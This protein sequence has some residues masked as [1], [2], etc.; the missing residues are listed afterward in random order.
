MVHVGPASPSRLTRSFR[1]ALGACSPARGIKLLDLGA[2]PIESRRPT[3]M[4]F[5]IALPVEGTRPRNRSKLGPPR[6]DALRSRRALPRAWALLIALLGCTPFE[7]AT[8]PQNDAGPGHA[9]PHR[10]MGEPRTTRRKVRQM[11]VPRRRPPDVQTP[12]CNRSPT[13]SNVR[14]SSAAPGDELATPDTTKPDAGDRQPGLEGH[15]RASTRNSQLLAS[16]RQGRVLATTAHD[17]QLQGRDFV[18]T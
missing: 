12:A 1:Q 3:R 14:A 18:S 8:E 5:S 13:A 4:P 6:R 7:T 9:H 15:G 10:R 17:Q 11:A 2:T 16:P